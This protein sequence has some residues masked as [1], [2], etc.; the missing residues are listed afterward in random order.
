MK[1]HTHTHTPTRTQNVYCTV[2]IYMHVCV[3]V[4]LRLCLACTYS[5][6]FMFWKD[7]TGNRRAWQCVCV[8]V[9][10]CCVNKRKHTLG[11]HTFGLSDALII[12][13]N[14][15]CAR[16][17]FIMPLNNESNHVTSD[18]DLVHSSYVLIKRLM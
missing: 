10:S 2:C 1:P 5:M 11:L 9:S 14:L 8:C 6:C 7:R 15:F 18:S 16:L 17:L 12:M 13:G 4:H 3:C